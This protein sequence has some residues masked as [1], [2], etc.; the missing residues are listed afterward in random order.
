MRRE[1]ASLMGG[2]TAALITAKAVGV[3]QD[4]ADADTRRRMEEG[5]KV[6]EE[7]E[8]KAAE[9]AAAEASRK[10]ADE[11]TVAEGT[12]KISE[13]ES[14]AASERAK[15]QAAANVYAREGAD[16]VAAQ[17]RYD[18][19]V[20]N[21]GSRKERSAALAA[22]QKEQAEAQEAKFEMEKAGTLQGINAQIKA[23]SSAVQKAQGRLSQNQA[24]APEG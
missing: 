9:K 5:R 22:L 21:G 15:A 2:D 23:L 17:N 13:L 1:A 10:A 16:V 7:T 11:K 18:M 14:S 12:T 8:R 20:T 6:R 3:Q 24:D 19:L 4:A